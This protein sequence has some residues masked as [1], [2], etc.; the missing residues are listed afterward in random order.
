MKMRHFPEGLA[1]AC[2]VTSTVER[3]IPKLEAH[4]T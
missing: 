3:W 4:H 1:N 2:E